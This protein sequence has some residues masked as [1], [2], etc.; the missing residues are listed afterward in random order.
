MWLGRH[1]KTEEDEGGTGGCS[2]A[3]LPNSKQSRAQTGLGG[4]ALSSSC[5]LLLACLQYPPGAIPHTTS[6]VFCSASC[7]PF[8]CP[9]QPLDNTANRLE[10]EVSVSWSFHPARKQNPSAWL[11]FISPLLTYYPLDWAPRLVTPRHWWSACS[12]STSLPPLRR[13]LVRLARLT[14]CCRLCHRP[15]H[16]PRL[17][18]PPHVAA[19]LEARASTK[20]HFGDTT[21]A[22]R[23]TPCGETGSRPPACQQRR[24]LRANKPEP[25]M[26]TRSPA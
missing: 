14:A 21:S 6:L 26:D 10:P 12:R 7:V 17:C 25:T 13:Y 16:L 3:R 18:S 11:L 22:T 23:P 19:I 8:L 20:C 1:Q 5:V 15:E 4:F 24:T 9:R 2:S